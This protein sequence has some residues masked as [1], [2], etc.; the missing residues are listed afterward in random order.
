MKISRSWYQRVLVLALVP[1]VLVSMLVAPA[2]AASIEGTIS[3]R[4]A[5]GI[6]SGN[7]YSNTFSIPRTN[8]SSVASVD[9]LWVL[10]VNA[11]PG[12]F[13]STATGLTGAIGY[14]VSFFFGVQ[15]ISTYYANFCSVLTDGSAIASDASHWTATYTNTNNTTGTVL[16]GPEITTFTASGYQLRSIGIQL[17]AHYSGSDASPIGKLNLTYSGNQMFTCSDTSGEAKGTLVFVVPSCSI[18]ATETSGELQELEDIANEIAT[19]NEILSAMYGDIISV[20]NSI[21]SRLGDM[22]AAMNLTNTYLQQVVSQLTS[23]NSTAANIYSLLGTYLHYLQSISETA[24]DIYA[25]LQAFHTDFMSMIEL[26]IGTVQTESDDIQAK[27]EEIYN[28]LIAYLDNI[29]ASAINPDQDQTIGDTN[30]VMQDS[31]DI[32]N[33]WTGN[34]MAGWGD[35]NLDAFAFGAQFLSAFVWVSSWFTNI[36]NGFGDFQQIIIFPL[37]VGI[38][39]LLVGMISRTSRHSDSTNSND[40]GEDNA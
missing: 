36:F 24:D 1:L 13:I 27:M 3:Y 25:E 32:E 30:D 2:S 37:L 17:S 15:S 40:G 12:A 16:G 14:Y 31:N 29:F 35:L 39:M 22:Q 19:G 26:L 11:R 21:Y 7:T 5:Y 20:L 9:N 18:V 34:M 23:L 8:A 28:L 4:F 33:E 6:G 10:Y 38:V